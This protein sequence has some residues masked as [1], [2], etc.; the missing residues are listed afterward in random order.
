MQQYLADLIKQGEQ[1][2]EEVSKDFG[3]LSSEQINWKPSPDKWSVGQCLEHLI[4]TNNNYIKILSK[5]VDGSYQ[6][7]FWQ[8]LG[9]LKGVW[10]KFFKK[11]VHPDSARKIKAPAAIRPHQSNIDSSIVNDFTSNIQTVLDL[12]KKL[13]GKDLS[14]ITISSPFASI[15]VYS[16]KDVCSIIIFHTQRHV[17]QAVRVMQTEGF[18]R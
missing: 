6:P 11:M 18:P 15:I 9:L 16:V 17:N 12:F 7:G 10:G 1:T 14:K 5:V 8:K 13:D 4:A 3:S 2:S